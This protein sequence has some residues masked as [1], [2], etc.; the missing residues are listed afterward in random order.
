MV[1]PRERSHMGIDPFGLIKDRPWLTSVLSNFP[2]YHISNIMVRMSQLPSLTLS[3]MCSPRYVAKGYVERL[4][5][6]PGGL[7]G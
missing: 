7:C 4:R 3:L 2:Y 6:V 1:G 5:G